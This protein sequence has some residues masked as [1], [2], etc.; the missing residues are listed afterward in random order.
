MSSFDY[1]ERIHARAPQRNHDHG[2]SDDYHRSAPDWGDQQG[3]AP[4]AAPAQRAAK[5]GG[6][7]SMIV[8]GWDS[9]VN[10]LG[11]G[12]A[13]GDGQRGKAMKAVFGGSSDRK[14]Q[15]FRKM[16]WMERLFGARKPRNGGGLPP[17]IKG[18][19]AQAGAGWA[20]ALVD[21]RD[22]GWDSF[23][24]PGRGT[25]IPDNQP[26]DLSPSPEVQS[27]QI[28]D[29]DQPEMPMQGG[30]LFMNHQSRELSREIEKDDVGIDDIDQRLGGNQ[31]G[32]SAAQHKQS[33]NVDDDLDSES[34]KGSFRGRNQNLLPAHILKFLE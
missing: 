5:K 4:A 29:L 22:G 30:G 33:F 16:P 27:K 32:F 7:G 10:G 18:P 6:L 28:D 31:W 13:V 8:R 1:A 12:K 25:K 34:D 17:G 3:D 2:V 15:G 9:F 11:L 24:G 14:M 21:A 23:N 26:E 19:T 20:D